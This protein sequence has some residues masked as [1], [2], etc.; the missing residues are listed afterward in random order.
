[1]SRGE[2]LAA[3]FESTNATLIAAVESL[4]DAQWGSLSVA[5]N[6][7]HA[8]VAH[9]VAVD[10]EAIAG[11]VQ[12]IATGATVPPLDM[13][14]LDSLN[15]EH[16]VQS[17]NCTK[18]ETVALLQASGTVAASMLRGLS[19]AQLDTTATIPLMGPDPVTAAQLAEDILV[20]H[21][22]M[23]LDSLRSAES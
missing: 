21:M 10:H 15:A 6:W 18:E 20:G 7:S 19:D 13:E 12:G 9:H 17:A 5:E 2:E 3:Q 14:A 4:S 23:H 1:M 22:N 16:A 8:V 11:L